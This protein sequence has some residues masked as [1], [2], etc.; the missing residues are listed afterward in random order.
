MIQLNALDVPVALEV[1]DLDVV[2]QSHRRILLVPED[3][4]HSDTNLLATHGL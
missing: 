3:V 2:Q 4:F 1:F